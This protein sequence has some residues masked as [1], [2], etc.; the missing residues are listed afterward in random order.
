[1]AG[2]P[3]GLA[4][5]AETLV[6]L[7]QAVQPALNDRW[8]SGFRVETQIPGIA[9]RSDIPHHS[10][11]SLPIHPG[12][13]PSQEGAIYV[14][15]NATTPLDP[16][17]AARMIE[18]SEVAWANPSS[19][20]RL[21]RAAR[22]ALDDARY[23]LSTLW[24]CKPSEIV[25]TSG[26]TESN[27]LAL[28]G[29]AGAVRSKGR[30]IVSTTVEHA[31]VSETLTQLERRD[32]FEVQRVPVDGSG[33]VDPSDVMSAIRS[34]TILVSVMA[35]NNEVGTLQPFAEIGRACRDRGILFHTDA[36]Q[37]FGKI[38]FRDILEFE[39]DLVSV[40]CHK[41]HG[42]KGAG[43]LFVR[44]PLRLEPQICGGSQEDER[45]GG[46]E[47]LPAIIGFVDAFR[48]FVP[49]PVFGRLP[50]G[51]WTEALA[52]A[53][54]LIPG[55]VRRGAVKDRLQNTLAVT[56]DGC[57]SIA[58]L[59]GLDLEGI[60]A[61]SG[62]ACAAGSLEPSRVL[63]AMGVESRLAHS[64]VRFSLGRY[65]RI[66][67]ITAIADAFAIVIGRIRAAGPRH[68]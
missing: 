31:A 32:G 39:A 44:S 6:S 63:R 10:R 36:V 43:A 68:P 20:H 53:L 55:V 13:N 4:P 3:T 25:F 66:E 34:D 54:V 24:R 52:R 17:V 2:P 19:V 7:P 58:L 14:D 30:H 46:T 26:G 57:D 41:F 67:D 59:A 18:V 60:G 50:L 16:A 45:R 40:C 62:S 65:N 61:S 1:M 33:R 23:E 22:A 47:N 11:V 37:A 64:L 21:G 48:R 51:E 27:N 15:Y 56:V 12:F 42:P 28:R 5:G 8:A 38:P 9:T 35:A 29:A 49:E